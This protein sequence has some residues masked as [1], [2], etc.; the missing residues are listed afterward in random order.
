MNGPLLYVGFLESAPWNTRTLSNRPRFK[1]VGTTLMFAAVE[2][3]REN[4]WHGRLG[5][6]SLPQAEEFYRRVGMT[7]LR[8]DPEHEGLAYY[9]LTA[10]TAALFSPEEQK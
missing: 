10:D 7:R 5:L 3:S 8:T 6:H 4:G 1:A 9:E 2:I